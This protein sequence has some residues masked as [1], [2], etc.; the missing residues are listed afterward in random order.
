MFDGS[1]SSHGPSQSAIQSRV[2]AGVAHLSA[3]DPTWFEGIDI[4]SLDIMQDKHCVLGQLCGAW[5][6]GWAKYGIANLHMAEA[7]GFA[8]YGEST[9]KKYAPLTAEWKRVICA[10]QE[11]TYVPEVYALQ[12]A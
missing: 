10:L 4:D 3:R 9:A 8:E 2:A 5:K 6:A 7:L 11:G 1:L 12:A